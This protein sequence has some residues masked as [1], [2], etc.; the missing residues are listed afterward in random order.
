MKIIKSGK[1]PEEK[2]SPAVACHNCGCI[3]Q[4]EA[5]EGEFVPDQRDGSYYR[6]GCPECKRINTVGTKFFK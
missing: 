2:T 6:I 4:F 1:P 5:R 3:F